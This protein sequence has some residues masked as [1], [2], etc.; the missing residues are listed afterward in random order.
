[1]HK[2]IHKNCDKKVPKN[3]QNLN[4][5]PT[6]KIVKFILMKTKTAKKIEKTMKL[7][8]IPHPQKNVNKK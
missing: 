6:K 2:K 4:K 1:M 7:K 8:K 5:N 3:I